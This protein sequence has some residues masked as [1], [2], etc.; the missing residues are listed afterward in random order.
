MREIH[1]KCSTWNKIIIY[2]DTVSNKD[3]IEH[4]QAHQDPIDTGFS[5]CKDSEWINDL[6]SEEFLPVS[7]N[8]GFSTIE[9]FGKDNE[10]LYNNA[11]LLS[12]DNKKISIKELKKLWKECYGENFEENYSGFIEIIKTNLMKKI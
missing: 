5:I 8:Q 9:F 10:I 7:E 12:E 1:Y 3:I 2:D 4:L 6:E 11:N